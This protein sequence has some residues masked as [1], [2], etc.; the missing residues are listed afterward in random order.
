MEMRTVTH[1]FTAMKLIVQLASV[2]A[3]SMNL[4][5]WSTFFLRPINSTIIEK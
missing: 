5:R 2:T 3:D 1:A 4:K